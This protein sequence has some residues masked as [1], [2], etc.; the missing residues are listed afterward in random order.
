MNIMRRD[1]KEN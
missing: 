1:S